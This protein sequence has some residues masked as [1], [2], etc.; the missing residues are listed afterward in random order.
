MGYTNLIDSIDFSNG[1]FLFSIG[2]ML[3][4]IGLLHLISETNIAV[5]VGP[6]KHLTIRSIRSICQMENSYIRS[7]ECRFPLPFWTVASN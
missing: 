2:K 3:F 6:H 1:E 7:E 4:S 5:V